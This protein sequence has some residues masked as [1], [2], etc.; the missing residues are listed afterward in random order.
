MVY[1]INIGVK[2]LK[3]AAS[4]LGC[5]FSEM[6]QEIKRAQRAGADTIHLDV[7]DGHFVPNISFGPAV[8]KSLRAYTDLPFEVHLMI[9]NPEKYLKDFANA[10]ADTIVF[11]SEIE[12]DILKII[13]E[14]KRLGKKAGIAVNP[15]TDIS[16]I[17][18]YIEYLD[19]VTIMTVHPG[20]GGQSFMEDQIYKVGKIRDK[21]KEVNKDDL[22]IE[23]DG[24][25]NLD[26]IKF[27]KESGVDICVSGSFLFN[28]ENVSDTVRLLKL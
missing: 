21:M 11:H 27:A 23:L 22:E 2:E 9:S 13:N 17:Y 7:M 10:G 6:G 28:S 5:D 19:L 15:E 26:T 14:V 18:P 8:I 16:K 1:F 25:I 24:G 20:F 3:I 4:I 12:G